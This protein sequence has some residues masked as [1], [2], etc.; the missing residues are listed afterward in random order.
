M[1]DVSVNIINENVK[2]AFKAAINNFISVQENLNPKDIKANIKRA[3][4]IRN[5]IN[6]LHL[7]PFKVL[8][9]FW[10][11]ISLDSHK[12]RNEN[13][14]CREPDTLEKMKM[15]E[16]MGLFRLLGKNGPTK[17]HTGA[18]NIQ[19]EDVGLFGRWNNF[20]TLDG[21]GENLD[22]RGVVGTCFDGIQCI[23]NENTGKLVVEDLNKGTFDFCHPSKNNFQHFIYD[24]LPWVVWSNCGDDHLSKQ[25]IPKKTWKEIEETWNKF[26]KG[27]ISKSEAQR[28][29]GNILD[30]NHP[31]KKPIKLTYNK[32]DRPDFYKLEEQEMKSTESHIDILLPHNKIIKVPVNSPYISGILAYYKTKAYNG[33]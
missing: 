25:V 15:L 9:G 1:S 33:L 13:Q 7:T 26:D 5:I 27:E 4:S 30:K 14:F 10:S 28:E 21:H 17:G 11:N 6:V 2:N 31:I 22:Y 12:N 16:D 19:K 20:L 24:V 23:Y 18:H 29:V 8:R 32:N 3:T